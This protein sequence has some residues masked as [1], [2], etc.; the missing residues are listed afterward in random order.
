MARAREAA[1]VRL[2]HLGL[3]NFFRAHQAW[4]TD[5]AS[6]ASEWGYAAFDGRTPGRVGL[7]APQSGVYTLVV[8][9]DNGDHQE[10]VQSLSAVHGALDAAAWLA[11]WRDPAV[12]IVTM[13]VTE[14]GYRADPPGGER[15]EVE[16]FLRDPGAPVSSPIGRVVAGL[17][18]RRDANA[19]P[20]VLLPC[21]NLPDN[22]RQLRNAVE[23][24]AA[25]VDPTLNEW[26]G[27][28]VEFGSTMVDRITPATTPEL[29]DLVADSTRKDDRSPVAT[30]PFTEWVIAAHF[31][32]GRPAWDATFVSDVRPYEERKLRL[33]NGAHS[34]LA[35]CGVM[36]GH[37]T[38]VQA[39]SDPTLRMWVE[40]WWDE[41]ST[42]LV[43]DAGSLQEYRDA[44]TRRFLNGR[45]RHELAQIS[46]DGS[47]KLVARMIPTIRALAA[48]GGTS[49][50]GC[51]AMGAWVAFLRR[52]PIP[53]KDP[54]ASELREKASRGRVR[55]GVSAVLGAIDP[56]LAQDTDVMEHVTGATERYLGQEKGAL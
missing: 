33:L 53:V 42:G 30:E 11:Y 29:I 48:E 24:F 37:A 25:E 21:D 3:G 19:G 45:I 46:A 9:D 54:R 13:T 55:D 44:L 36:R 35:Y 15:E 28:H 40:R 17:L 27:H 49:L 2:L 6:D 31:P 10:L 1:P 8:R 47:E 4:Y 16:A 32:Q 56:A 20:V 41:A 5:R 52:P 51:E 26:I 50:A 22:G 12:A 18:A 7:L 14:A 39:M 43:I 38:V 23:A 34:L